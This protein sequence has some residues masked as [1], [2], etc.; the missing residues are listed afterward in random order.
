MRDTFMSLCRHFSAIGGLQEAY[1]IIYSL[2]EAPAGARLTLRRTGGAARTDSLVL[3]AAPER[4]YG[5]LR[6]LCENA[7]QPEIWRDVVA[8]VSPL[9][10]RT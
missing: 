8:E 7:V 2:D 10:D 5:L 4:C 6:Y 1:T 3:P 9:L